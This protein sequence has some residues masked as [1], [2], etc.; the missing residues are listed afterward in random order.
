[1][2]T[3][4]YA[5][6]GQAALVGGGLAA[7]GWSQRRPLRRSA[8]G[9]AATAQQVVEAA[10]DV[11]GAARSYGMVCCQN[12][13]GDIRCRLMDLHARQDDDQLRLHMI[14]RPWTRKA[15][16]LRSAELATIT[17]H[18][19]RE[20]GE[21]GYASLSGR[22]RELTDLAERRSCWK[23]SWSWFHPGPEGSSVIYEFT[24][25][26]CEVVNH[27]RSVAPRWR[28]AT[29]RCGEGGWRLEDVPQGLDATATENR[30]FL[31]PL[32]T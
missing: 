32:V 24:P 7:W 10:R 16:Q 8:N 30:A 22:V 4:R 26:R 27:R 21:N 12:G 17:F 18:D 19:P 9:Q 1:M 5:L 20:G 13:A 29:V 25:H 14:T 6:A 15:S 23:G 31:L 3:L 11:V 28:P 2:S